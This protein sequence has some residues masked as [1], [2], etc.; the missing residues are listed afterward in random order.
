AGAG[1][2]AAGAAGLELE[3]AGAGAEEEA[4]GAVEV[5]ADAED[6]GLDPPQATIDIVRVRERIIAK[7]F[8][9]L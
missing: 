1:F 9:I 8:F 7:N 3:A 5:E 4:A 6:E 2:D